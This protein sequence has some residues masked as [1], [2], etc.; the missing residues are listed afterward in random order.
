MLELLR[1]I[2]YF[3]NFGKF[4]PSSLQIFLLT[5][6]TLLLHSHHTYIR[7]LVLFKKSLK[8]CSLFIH[9][10]FLFIFGFWVISTDLHSGSLILVSTESGLQISPLK[11]FFISVNVLLKSLAS[12]LNSM[13][14]KQ[15]Y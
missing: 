5:L 2:I 3:F 8:L 1:T 14:R 4:W 15:Q 12:A 7:L 6:Y 9:S 11:A 13:S 10:L